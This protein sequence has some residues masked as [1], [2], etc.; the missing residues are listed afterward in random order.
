[1]DDEKKLIVETED[2]VANDVIVDASPAEEAP[3][4]TASDVVAAF[5]I[6]EQTLLVNMESTEDAHGDE[7]AVAAEA[8]GQNSLIDEI[9]LE[10]NNYVKRFKMDFSLD[11][12]PD[13]E[14]MGVGTDEVP[15]EPV[16]SQESENE[17]VLIEET[18]SEEVMVAE[19]E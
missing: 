6:A 9:L 11:D 12:I 1:M 3:S 19:I 2:V 18:E 4:V 8:D 7:G 13:A 5:N 16:E 15:T 10:R 14:G 17:P